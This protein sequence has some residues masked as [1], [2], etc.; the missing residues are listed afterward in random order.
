VSFIDNLV[1]TVSGENRIILRTTDSG[2]NWYL[3]LVSPLVSFYG[4][5]FSDSMNGVATGNNGAIV[6][7]TN[8]GENWNTVQD[9]W[10]LT[11]NAAF[12]LDTLWAC[13]V[14]SNSIFQPMINVTTDGWQTQ[15]SY[16]FYLQ[17]G[18]N[19]EGNLRDVHFF[20]QYNGYAAAMVWNG[21]GAIVRTTDGGVNWETAYWGNN[22]IYALDFP[23]P[24]TG[25]AVGFNGT[26]L[27]TTNAGFNWTPLNVG[28]AVELLD[29]S[30]AVADTG[31]AVGAFGFILRTVDGGQT[32]DLQDAGITGHLR[33]VDFPTA[34]VGY[35]VGDSGI[36]LYT[37]TG[38][39]PPSSC[40]YVPGDVNYNGVTNGL[41][42]VYLVSYLKGGAEPPLSCPCGTHGDL[43][44]AGDANGSCDV[45]GLDVTYMITYFKGGPDI[46]PCPDCPPTP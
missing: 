31:T 24:D 1:G 32:W 45:N 20:D 10:W 30:F 37:A 21:E 19:H 27:K 29:V 42:V 23:T 16:I 8:G 5:S 2:Q 40:D 25:Y 11:F 34:K 36:I 12:Q 43:Y 7:T 35:V 46:I 14:G 28:Y 3:Q 15:N 39:E 41:D 4:V 33:G 22:V 26:A 18:G 6:S 9:G 38:G 17:H 44:V 13:V